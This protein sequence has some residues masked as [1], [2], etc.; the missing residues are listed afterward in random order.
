[1][2][3]GQY[4]KISILT[5]NA[6]K[7][8]FISPYNIRRAI[9]RTQTQTMIFDQNEY[10]SLFIFMDKIIQQNEELDKDIQ[11]FIIS[12]KGPNFE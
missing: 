3:V 5:V 8:H 11:S 1:M 4:I 7:F 6:K 10:K 2:Q 12:L 9:S